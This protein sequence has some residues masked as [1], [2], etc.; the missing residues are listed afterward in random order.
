MGYTHY[1][2]Y[3][4]ESEQWQAAFPRLLADTRTILD[5]LAE[6]GI[7]TADAHGDGKP[8]LTA[9]EIVFNGA[10]PDEYESFILR[11]TQDPDTRHR[12]WRGD[13]FTWDF[14]KT[15]HRPYDLAVTATLLRAQQLVPW[16]FAIGS[17]GY[18]DSDWKPA[19][20][21]IAELFE[22]F[23]D[24]KPLTDTSDGPAILLARPN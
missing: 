6:H 17:D 13:H 11:T 14:C 9:D 23:T 15:A 20:D 7:T 3:L 22:P 2:S 19:R 21:L 16:H 8:Q 24:D 4:P 18:W 5:H 1:W 10:E 12:T